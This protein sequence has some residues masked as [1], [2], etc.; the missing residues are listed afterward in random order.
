MSNG[1]K[2]LPASEKV[3][4]KRLHIKTREAE[5]SIQRRNVQAELTG[6]NNDIKRN[7]NEIYDIQGEFR[8]SKT[9][10]PEDVQAKINKLKTN[11]AELENEKESVNY[12]L[13]EI[14]N[15]QDQCKIDHLRIDEEEIS[16][17][18]YLKRQIKAQAA[19]VK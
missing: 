9:A 17:R 14:S 8:L 10:P 3:K 15:E 2:D 18:N 19:V 16:I 11:I 6:L 4:V 5:L 7:N 12:T 13:A 1:Y